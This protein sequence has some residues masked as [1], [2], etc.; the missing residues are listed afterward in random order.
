VGLAIPGGVSAANGPLRGLRGLLLPG[1]S[2]VVSAPLGFASTAELAQ[3][4][5]AVTVTN[6]S[7]RSFAVARS[8]FALAAQGDIFG[9]QGWNAGAARVTIPARRSATIRLTFRAP[10]AALTRANFVYGMADEAVSGAI[11][12][13][14]TG[15]FTASR[16]IST[17]PVRHA[18]P[19]GLALDK[20]GDVW[21]TEAGCDFSPTCPSGT[22]PGQ[23]AELKASSHRVVYH[24]LPNIPGNQPIF[25]AFDPRG[26]LW[27]TTPNNGKI[28]EFKPSTGRFV[29]Q[30]NVTSGSG[31]WDLTFSRGTIW[32]T[33]HLVSAVGSFNPSTHRHRDFATPSANSNPYGI[34][35]SAGGLIWFTED[36][37]TVDRVAV[38]NPH[39]RGHP[40]SEYPIVQPLSGTPHMIAINRDGHP[41]WTEGFSNTIATLNPA[42]AKPGSCPQ[43]AS[44][45]C[46]GVRRFQLPPS[47]SCLGYGS[48]VSG[49]AI[50]RRSGLVWLDDSLSAQVGSFSPK[51]HSFALETLGGCNDHPDDGLG[52]GFA[53]RLWFDEEFA[54][55]VG[56]LRP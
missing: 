34:A 46:Q 39:K 33:E 17:F 13:D 42:S 24:R 44:G 36:N 27:F 22:P 52:L 31:P 6:T 28:G 29:G 12:L 37:S 15:A 47:S 48:H 19:W 41:W 3:T 16:R 14:R 18:F 53:N 9:V 21:F 10:S 11:P 23:I 51:S 55:A 38:L 30:W 35:A 20:R 7:S 54:S 45:T 2:I 26:N 50:Q 32:Y 5:L 43:T 25:L 49:I 40:I 4:N 8:D 56:E 1:R